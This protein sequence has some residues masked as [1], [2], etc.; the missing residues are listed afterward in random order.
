MN[1][2]VKLTPEELSKVVTEKLKEQLGMDVKSV[3]FNVQVVDTGYG[4]YESS[5]HQFTGCTVELVAKE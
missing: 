4:R 3:V 5:T 2:S 1:L